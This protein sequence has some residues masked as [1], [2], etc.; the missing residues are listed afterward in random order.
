MGV[1]PRPLPPVYEPEAVAEAIIYTAKHPISEVSV[2]W[3]SKMLQ[4]GQAISPPLVDQYFLRSGQGFKN[5]RT[6]R[7][8]DGVDNLFEPLSKTGSAHGEFSAESKPNSLYTRHIELH[9]ARKL[10]L[11]G[12]VALGAAFATQ[13]ALR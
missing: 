13:R 5:Q 12:V 6:D 3:P 11:A 2:G 10:L 1:E 9:P 7:P 8:D 4:I